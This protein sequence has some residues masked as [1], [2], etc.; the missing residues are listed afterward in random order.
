MGAL[1]KD[2]GLSTREEMFCE[3]YIES[4]NM[5]KAYMTVYK[6]D[7]YCKAKSEAN[8]L[9]KN[10]YVLAYIRKLQSEIRERMK[11][12]PEFLIEKA[13][14]VYEKSIQAK[15]VLKLNPKTN[16]LEETGQYVFDGRSAIGA[17]DIIASVTGLKQSRIDAKLSLEKVT[18]KD[19][20]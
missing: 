12:T 10:P 4:F 1:N 2:T 7:N 20:I 14:D 15:P 8:K 19:D 5:T 9:M 11:I 18:I 16:Q 17:L 3:L 6:R 13:L